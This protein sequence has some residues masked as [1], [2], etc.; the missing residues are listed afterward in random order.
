MYQDVNQ[1]QVLSVATLG[2]QQVLHTHVFWIRC[3]TTAVPIQPV[4]NLHQQTKNTQKVIH[5]TV[6]YSVVSYC[7]WS[8]WHKGIIFS[9]FLHLWSVLCP[10]LTLR[11]HIGS[12]YPFP[13]GRLGC[14]RH[15]NLTP[16][17]DEA[18]WFLVRCK[19]LMN[20]E[21]EAASKSP[22]VTTLA[23]LQTLGVRSWGVPSLEDCSISSSPQ[24]PL[25]R[26]CRLPGS[27]PG[28]LTSLNFNDLIT[29]KSLQYRC[30]VGPECV[31]HY[32]NITWIVLAKSNIQPNHN[33]EKFWTRLYR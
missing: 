19:Y 8:Y 4:I 33:T 9:R 11:L 24:G 14:K 28:L 23:D 17:E 32:Y 27:L 2:V 22:D 30:I 20:N 5:L 13:Y 18:V 15:I 29:H 1:Q 16:I 21:T 26:L 25:S 6:R 31:K 12:P 3:E 7:Y 10:D